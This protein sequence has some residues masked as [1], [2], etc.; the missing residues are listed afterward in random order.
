MTTT[1]TIINQ[2][3]ASLRKLAAANDWQ[4]QPFD[5]KSASADEDVF[6]RGNLKVHT[7]WCARGWFDA[8]VGRFYS[9]FL[10]DLTVDGQDLACIVDEGG[11]AKARGWLKA[12]V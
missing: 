6:I 8:P 10:I 4:L 7:S 12:A 2:S 11:V 1:T 3:R 5:A 9:A